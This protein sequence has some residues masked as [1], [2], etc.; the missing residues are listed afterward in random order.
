VTVKTFIS[1]HKIFISNKCC[2]FELAVR[3]R[4]LK[5]MSPIQQNYYCTTVINIENDNVSSSSDHH[6]K[7][8]SEGSCDTAVMMLKI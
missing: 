5:N 6:M 3:Q 8:I 1:L 4:I 2:S 7:M